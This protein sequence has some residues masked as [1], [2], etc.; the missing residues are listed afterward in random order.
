MGSKNAVG[1][2]TEISG[3][4]VEINEKAINKFRQK[5]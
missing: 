4:K 2:M 3:G 5:N 1:G